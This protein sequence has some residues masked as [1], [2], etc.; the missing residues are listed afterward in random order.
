MPVPTQEP[1]F[2]I[3]LFALHVELSGI[4]FIKAA[5][6]DTGARKYKYQDLPSLM[7]QIAPVLHKHKFTWSS[8]PSV[9]D[10]QATLVYILR[11]ISGETDE[12]EML[13]MS[14]SLSPQDQGG[15]ITY[16]RRYAVSAQL[17]IVSDEDDD[18]SKAQTAI[19]EV[20]KVAKETINDA[21]M[22][23]IYTMLQRLGKTAEDY[24]AGLTAKI[25]KP[26]KISDLTNEQGDS[27]IA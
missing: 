16:A 21:R 18:A 26:T 6:G 9:K 22:T 5:T 24:E 8:K 7:A 20:T 13:L 19:K 17:G 23:K 12:G 10:G 11:H 27:I 1:N 3:D 14:K 25:G 4:D 15:A 2:N